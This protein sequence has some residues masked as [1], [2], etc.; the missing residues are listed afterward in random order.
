M[1]TSIRLIAL[2]LF[3]V[4]LDAG[5]AELLQLS[6]PT[7]I[8]ARIKS[9]CKTVGVTVAQLPKNELKELATLARDYI[10]GK[11]YNRPYASLTPPEVRAYKDAISNALKTLTGTD[12]ARKQAA[13]QDT[14]TQTEGAISSLVPRDSVHNAPVNVA[15]AGD[16]F[17]LAMAMGDEVKEM[18]TQARK[19]LKE[20]KEPA[21]VLLA[22]MNIRLYE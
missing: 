18:L 9:V 10:V 11:H 13:K 12:K 15:P 21:S 17:L 4:E 3:Q 14:E 7:F 20:S 5:Y 1:D 6:A 16:G 19:V 8:G 22:Q 2:S